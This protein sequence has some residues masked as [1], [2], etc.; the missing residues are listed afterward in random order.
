M[1]K[2]YVFSNTVFHRFFLVLASEN[3]PK[4]MIFSIILKNVDFVKIMVFLKEN[5]CFSGFELSKNDQ[6]S[7]PTPFEKQLEKNLPK[8]DFG[9]IWASPKF[10]KNTKIAPR[11]DVK[12]SLFRD[13]MELTRK[14]SE[15]NGGRR[16]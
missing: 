2:K 15:V 14:S 1:L 16:L 4:S 7:M 10:P 9:I 3:V 5:W 6:R 13:A 11:S 8:F 12:R